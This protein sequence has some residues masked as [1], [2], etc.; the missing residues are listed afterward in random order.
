MS[1]E[2]GI[3]SVSEGMLRKYFAPSRCVLSSGDEPMVSK[4]RV[5]LQMQLMR[6]RSG[7]Q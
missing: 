3:L 5:K 1:Y 4:C 7:L 6:W 2:P